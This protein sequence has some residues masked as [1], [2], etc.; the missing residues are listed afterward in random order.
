MRVECGHYLPEPLPVACV[1]QE[2]QVPFECFH[3]IDLLLV[4]KETVAGSLRIRE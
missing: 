3:G 2:L 4:R 1:E